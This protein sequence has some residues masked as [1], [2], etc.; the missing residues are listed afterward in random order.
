MQ[1]LFIIK[2]NQVKETENIMKAE[3]KIAPLITTAQVA[4]NSPPE[5]PAKM[6]YAEVSSPFPRTSSPT[7]TKPSP[8]IS[9]P[10]FD[11]TQQTKSENILFIGDSISS[12]VHIKQLEDATKTSFVTAKAYSAVND[13]QSNIAKQ[14]ARFPEVNFTDVVRTKLGNDNFK[15]LLLQAGAVDI[16]NLNTNENPE[17]YMEYYKQVAIISANNLFEAATNAIKAK[18]SLEKVIIMKQIPRYD[19]HDVDPLGLKPSLSLLFNNTLGS[20]WL[21][22]PLR[23]KLFVGDHNIECNGAIREA[24]YRHTRTGRFDGIHLYGSS[25][26]KAYTNSVLNILK[27][28]QVTSPDFHGPCEQFRHQNRQIRANNKQTGSRHAKSLTGR[29]KQSQQTVFSVPTQNRFSPL[30][31]NQGNW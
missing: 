10:V 12:N 11:S 17:E 29:V 9:P 25:G 15:T 22:S 8:K 14:A 27:L 30:S 4:Q 5:K 6:S 19:P 13:T 7:R 31:Q 20:L 28:A 16:T 3:V 1:E 21:D 23:H 26:R 2:N 24:R 18:P